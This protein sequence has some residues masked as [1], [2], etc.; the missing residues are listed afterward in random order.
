VVAA[1]AAN[2]CAGVCTGL[3]GDM[4]AK[5]Q[6]LPPLVINT[7]GWITGL[8]L[9]LLAEVLRCAAPTHGECGVPGRGLGL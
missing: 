4:H 5:L 1:N 9:D 3:D 2:G 6:L 8:G 7:P